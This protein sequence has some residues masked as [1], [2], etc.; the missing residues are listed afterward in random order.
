[1]ET[2][3]D[4]NKVGAYSVLPQP[5]PGWQSYTNTVYTGN[6]WITAHPV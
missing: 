3:Q 1:M 4:D 6:G 2:M 5:Q